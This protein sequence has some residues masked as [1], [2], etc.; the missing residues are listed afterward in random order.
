MEDTVLV[1]E[2][3][4]STS[5]YCCT[6][7]PVTEIYAATKFTAAFSSSPFVV[8]QAVFPICTCLSP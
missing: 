3:D 2:E 6:L 7:L 1:A 8:M 5:C 4:S